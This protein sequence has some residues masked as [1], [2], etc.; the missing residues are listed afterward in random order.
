MTTPLSQVDLITARARQL[1]RKHDDILE[2]EKRLSRNRLMKKTLHDLEH[3]NTIKD[4]TFE[5]GDLV[6]VRNSQIEMKLDRKAKPRWFGPMTVVKR[7]KG[8]SYVLAELDGTISKLRYGAFR[9]IPYYAR[10]SAKV[11]VKADIDDL[12]DGSNLD[13]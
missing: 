6:L 5:E 12:S 7:T 2:A 1:R 10:P 9:L 3:Q 4:Y 11:L 13:Q 8:G